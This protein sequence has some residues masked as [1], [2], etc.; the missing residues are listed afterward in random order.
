MHSF[1]KKGL[2]ASL[3]LAGLNALPAPAT[4]ASPGEA[5]LRIV[6][7]VSGTG[8][9]AALGAPERR[10]LELAD[11]TVLADGKLPFK[12][13]HIIYD[14]G[15]D[16][17]KAVSL[18]RKG[19]EEDRADIII[20][21]TTTPGSMAILETVK[22]AKVPQISMASAI[23]IV[24]P[25]KDRPFTF[26][27]STSDRLILDR[28]MAYMKRQGIKTVAFFGVDTSYGETGLKELYPIA[29]REG[30]KVLGAERFASQDTNFTPQAIRL[31]Q[32][33]PDAIYVHA[34]P[35]AAILAQEALV[36]IGFTGPVFHG[37]GSSLQSFVEVGKDRVE[38]AYVGVGAL[39]VYDQISASNEMRPGLMSF[40]ALYDKAYGAGTV[41]EFAGQAWDAV[42]LSL[43]AF[44]AALA[45]GANA[46]D[47]PAMRIAIRD[48]LEK[49]D[50]V[51]VIG[52]YK[53]RPEDHLGLDKR[54]TFLS[55]IQNGKFIL[56]E[57]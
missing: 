25:A 41:D 43:K 30:I 11:K 6:S 2:A 40:G 17:T 5:E 37:D 33:K 46:D 36:R 50:H 42:Q 54:S 24:E 14:D 18:A 52:V 34:I 10:A 48:A 20:C 47:L 13:K 51:G 19:I 31:R 28:L 29:E 23:S 22:A 12:V 26:S 1:L 49:T 38:G 44:G 27:T 39:N 57:E 56:V 7:I 32:L 15:S 53:I 4:A 9:A 16:P 21:C 55:K 35:P 8:P 3:A 45:A